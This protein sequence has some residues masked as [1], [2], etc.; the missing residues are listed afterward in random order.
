MSDDTPGSSTGQGSDFTND[1]IPDSGFDTG[2]DRGYDGDPYDDGSD[3]HHSHSDFG[4]DFGHR[5]RRGYPDLST[6]PTWVKVFTWVGALTAIAGIGIAA[7]GIIGSANDAFDPTR[8]ARWPG[9]ST[10]YPPLAEQ[11][12]N[13]RFPGGGPV[14]TVEGQVLNLEEVR[15]VGPADPV[16]ESN[17]VGLGLGLFFVGFVLSAVAALGHST[18]RRR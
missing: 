13:G 3:H 11:L 14:V 4:H 6:A 2:Y 7:F 17:P 18:T 8:S 9:A 5:R 12:P 15:V 16:E 1:G 10:S